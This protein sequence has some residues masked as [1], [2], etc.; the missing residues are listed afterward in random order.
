[1]NLSLID[2]ENLA[3]KALEASGVQA[4]AAQITARSLVRAD[5]DGMASHGLSR[6][7]QY[8][9]HVRVGRVNAQA[10]PCVVA[11]RP[12]AAVVDAQEGFAFPAMQLAVAE[13]AA[14]TKTQGVSFIAVAN[15]HHFGV[16]GHFAE[17]L[18]RQ[19][20]IGLVVGNSPAAMPMWGGRRAVFGTNPIAAAF[21]RVKADPVL[22]DLS[23]S[24]VARGKLMVAAQKGESIPEGWALNSK[25]EPT[26]D[27]KEGLT[28]MMV[29][30]GGAKGA[31]LAFMVEAL[32]VAVSNSA[33]GFE[34]DSFFELEGNRPRIAQAL[35]AIDI[36]L[37]SQEGYFQR[38]EDLITYISQ[39]PEVRLP[40]ERRFGLRRQAERNGISISDD[41]YR[42]LK[43][44]AQ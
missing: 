7:P 4:R 26:T 17:D 32:C 6:V 10:E 13:A 39:D 29:P 38:M 43:E 1:M 44:L 36:G 21:P 18:A 3:A 35:L 8:A 2:A 34:A 33:Y 15:S 19:G 25:G 9:G 40:G 31:M 30:A 20:L 42:Q 41:L 28:G 27:P 24:A 11:S 23:L 12:A 22:I 5:A 16:A 14:R 37:K